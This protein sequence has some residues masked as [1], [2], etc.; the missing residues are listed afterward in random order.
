MQRR[1]NPMRWLILGISVWLLSSTDA[2]ADDKAPQYAADI[3][4]ILQAHCTRCHGEKRK[5]GPAIVLAKPHESLLLKKHHAGVMPPSKQ[6][7][8]VG[9]KPSTSA[10][11]ERLARWI[12]LGCPEVSIAPDV[13]GITPDPLVS[14]KD[15]DFWSF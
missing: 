1:F 5:R 13:A 8:I 6:L 7:I 11:T 9:V 12:E 10:E 15:R 3:A 4:P 14:E 2:T